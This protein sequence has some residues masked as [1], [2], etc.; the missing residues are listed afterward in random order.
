[1]GICGALGFYLLIYRK[2]APRPLYNSVVYHQSMKLLHQHP[3][4]S[5]VI[6][7]NPLVMNCNGKYWPM[8]FKN[9]KFDLTVFGEEKAKFVVK[10]ERSE[11]AWDIT[12]VEM[13]TKSRSLKIV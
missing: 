2:I 8:I 5:K 9:S 12:G 7:K 1:M 13:Y 4:T 10:T 11:G 6:G 3:V